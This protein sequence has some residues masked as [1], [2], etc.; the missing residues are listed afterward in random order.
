MELNIFDIYTLIALAEEIVPKST[1]FRDRYFPTNEDEDIFTSDKVL[2]EYQKGSRKMAAFVAERA[3]D[4]PV[5]RTGYEVNELQPAYI[6][7]SRLLTLDDLKKRGFG[8]AMFA[9]SSQAQ[10]AARLTLKDLNDLGGMITLREEWMC[11][12]TMINNACE[13]QTYIDAKTEGKKLSVQF[14]A[15]KSEHE[16]T[17]KTPINADK[18]D[19]F[20]T[21]KTMCRM[22]SKRGLAAA[23]LVLGSQAADAIT[24]IPKV[25]ALLD[26][27]RMEYGSLNPEL[28][29]HPGVAHMGSLNFGG[30]KLNLFDVAHSYVENG[31]EKPYFPAT[32]A[33]VTAPA[34]GKLMYG[35]ITQIDHGDAYH[36]THTGS[37]IPKLVI[38]QNKDTRKLRLGAR[39]LATPRSYCPF[40]YA[41][42]FVK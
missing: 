28:T 3:G 41:E 42:N 20:G 16:Y 39:P 24:S 30:F 14:Y 29:A 21:V 22:L 17:V 7:P 19:F 6:A 35:S 1:F 5:D 26:N 15:D 37:R 8:E 10:R 31:F 34:C 27:R 9:G 33:M 18:G 38:E 13:M 12:Q 40:I 11:V 23:D 4:I 36:T 32:S 25:Q 2:T